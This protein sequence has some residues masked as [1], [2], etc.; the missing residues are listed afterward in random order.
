[1]VACLEEECTQRDE[2]TQQSRTL[3]GLATI[4][5][6]FEGKS[7]IS[8]KQSY[9]FIQS[10]VNGSKSQ[11]ILIVYR[12]KHWCFSWQARR[13]Y[14]VLWMTLCVCTFLWFSRSGRSL[15]QSCGVRSGWA[16]GPSRGSGCPAGPL[17]CSCG[18]PSGRPWLR[19]QARWA[20]Q[21]TG[22]TGREEL[23]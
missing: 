1:M 4:G 23:L 17:V 14:G 11:L 8:R 2:W 18:R 13:L 3:Q 12:G 20:R 6:F 5:R 16:A 7:I 19:S 10:M 9:C 15:G 22:Q 21:P